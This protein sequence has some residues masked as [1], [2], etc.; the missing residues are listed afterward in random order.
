[1][2]NKAEREPRKNKDPLTIQ[3]TSYNKQLEDLNRQFKQGLISR[4]G[5]K[6][7]RQP[8]V[9]KLHEAMRE[10]GRKPIRT[11]KKSISFSKKAWQRLPEA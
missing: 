10:S 5:H 2:G 8:I 9:V 3:I 7:Q 4:S 6:A 1:M 11:K